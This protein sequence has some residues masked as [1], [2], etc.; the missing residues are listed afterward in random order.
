MSEC[1]AFKFMIIHCKTKFNLADNADLAAPQFLSPHY[2]RTKERVTV[3]M[4]NIQ[5]LAWIYH[6]KA[7]NWI[8]YSKCQYNFKLINLF[9]YYN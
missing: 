9:I 5:I 2:G 1:V 8:I 4:K 3:D 6:E 7:G